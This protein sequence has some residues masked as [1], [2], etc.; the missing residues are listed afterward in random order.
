M[1]VL[2]EEVI[3]TQ[4]FLELIARCLPA[5]EADDTLIGVSAWNV[6]GLS[7]SLLSNNFI[8]YIIQAV[9]DMYMWG[10]KT[11]PNY[12]SNNFDKPR[13]ILRS[14]GTRVL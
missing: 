5:I 4:D 3:A 8:K 10:K 11:A 2:E 12:F 14:F 6:N 1:I 9:F 7:L 13:S